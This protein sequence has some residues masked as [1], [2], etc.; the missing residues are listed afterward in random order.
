MT[1][2]RRLT[3]AKRVTRPP[4]ESEAAMATLLSIL[5]GYAYRCQN[6]GDW[7]L[8]FVSEGVLEVTGYSQEEFLVQRSIT[9]A[10]KI[11]DDDRDRVRDEIQAAL[12]KGEPFD[13][14]YRI[15][16][17]S[18]EVRCV[19]DQG[20]TTNAA[21]GGSGRIEGFVSDITGRR[22]AEEA[23]RES[24]ERYRSLFIDTPAALHTIDREGRLI[25][26]SDD[27]LEL[28]GYERKEVIGRRSVEFLTEESRR[29]AETTTLPDFWK[30]GRA[31]N[32]SYQFRRKNG[33]IVDALLNAV[34]IHNEEGQF[35]TSIVSLTDVTE[36][37][38]AEKELRKSEERIR[39]LLT[40]MPDMMF[41]LSRDGVVLDHHA[42]SHDDLYVSPDE[43]LGKTVGEVMPPGLAKQT[44]DTLGIVIEKQ[45]VSTFEYQLP[46]RGKTLD[47]EAR[48]VPHG[49][50][51]ALA[52][53]RNI[54]DRKKAEATIEHMAY[55]D[56]L[57]DLPNRT[58]LKD[59]LELAIAQ[60]RRS[61]RKVA[62]MFLDVDRFKGINDTLG[63]RAGDKLLQR[64]GRQLAGVV[65][66]GDT[67]ARVGGDEFILLLPDL[68]DHDDARGV[69]ERALGR[70]RRKR[71]LASRELVI[72]ASLGISVYPSD[73]DDAEA[74]LSHADTAM[75]KAKEQGRDQFEFY[76]LAMGAKVLARFELDGDIRRALA[77]DEFVV[78]YQPQIAIDSGEIVGIEALIRWQHPERGLLL[79]DEFIGV[80]QDSGLM[81][82]LDEQ[83]LRAASAQCVAWQRAHS[84]SLSLSVNFETN[85]LLDRGLPRMVES[86]LRSSGL[87]PASLVVE[88]T[89]QQAVQDLAST[90]AALRKLKAMG[91]QIAV[92]DFGTGH[93]SLAYLSQFPIDVVKI[94][95]SFVAGIGQTPEDSAIVVA[96]VS[97]ARGL[98]LRVIAEGVETEDQLGFLKALRCDE[99]QGY[100]FSKPVPPQEFERLL[101]ASGSRRFG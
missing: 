46:I 39:A 58:L 13:V 88:I 73:G 69:A 81:S 61:G 4:G 72:T 5:P 28:L 11:H 89:E 48:Y 55:H 98:G 37:N 67:V 65:R 62:V 34:A 92:D 12:A 47:F 91:V 7:T 36:R 15:I 30:T 10:E 38:R 41:V 76:N 100:L 35:T 78:H 17:K 71:R 96:I 20:R 29:Y 25:E 79:P 86:I 68:V 40:A 84:D 64:I 51:Q 9:C 54:T 82:R 94:D 93:S 3:I 101:S 83:T 95:R 85:A 18:G 77:Q 2:R 90:Q 27:W 57:T 42:S 59:H 60:A 70:I 74:L 8:D 80:A 16:T 99:F 23:L 52:V 56:S 43:F 66:D 22:R 32:I 6:D 44:M 19:Q 26:V 21:I 14:T 97:M 50:D 45:T 33:E 49:D 75:Y 31:R 24:E 1:R 63:H 53:I 87:A